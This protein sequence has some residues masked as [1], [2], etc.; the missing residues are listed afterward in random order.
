MTAPTSSMAAAGADI[1]GGF[2]GDDIYFVDNAGDVVFET[3][4]AASTSVFTSVSYELG[5]DIERLSVNG[6]TTTSRSTSSATASTNEISGNDGANTLDGA[7]RRRHPATA[8]AARTP[9]PSPPRSAAAMSTSSPTSRPGSTGS[10]STM[11]CSPGLRPARLPAGAFR[12]GTS[13]Q[14]ADDRIIYDPVSGALLF[15][16]D[17]N[18]AGAAVQF[19]TLPS[20]TV[21]SASDFIVI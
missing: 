11:P 8:A 10:R 20:G 21:L 5:D 1:M 6:F 2:G 7:R 4:A 18:G 9:S 14:D 17:G 19:A 12:T 16:A 15:D 13:A 3:S